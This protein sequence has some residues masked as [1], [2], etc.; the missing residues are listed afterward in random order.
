MFCRL[1]LVPGRLET[2]EA[3]E[4]A[5]ALTPKKTTLKSTNISTGSADNGR[6]RRLAEPWVEAPPFDSC[7]SSSSTIQRQERIHSRGS[8]S[9]SGIDKGERSPWRGLPIIPTET[10]FHVLPTP[11][12]VEKF[13]R[14]MLIPR[15]S[16]NCTCEIWP[17]ADR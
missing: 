10:P 8:E 9:V 2:T 3:R 11:A 17:G 13:T 14:L 4:G 15:M 16:C 6:I 7:P 12:D 5:S 1:V